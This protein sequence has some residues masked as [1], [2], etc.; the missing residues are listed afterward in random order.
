V[1]PD[2]RYKKNDITKQVNNFIN[3]TP[4]VEADSRAASRILVLCRK[5]LLSTLL[6]S[7][8][9][10]RQLTLTQVI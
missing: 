9:P 10:W 6:A 5:R 2:L 3:W 1:F 8:R 7:V 4:P